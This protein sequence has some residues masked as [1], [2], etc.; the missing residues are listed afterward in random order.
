MRQD[1]NPTGDRDTLR[2]LWRKL[3]ESEERLKFFRKMVGWGLSVRE[4][5][6]LGDDLNSKFRSETMK[7][8]HSEKV[9]VNAIMEMK[10]KDE[11]RFQHEMKGRKEEARRKLEESSKSRNDFKKIIRQINGE[12]KRWRKMEKSKFQS[13][14]EHIKRI[15]E[16][17]EIKSLQEC[18][19]EI[20][21]YAN[22]IIFSKKEFEKLKKER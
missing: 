3:I 4:I 14:I 20:K 6:H 8:G 18:P 5:E 15:R 1:T 12:A 19:P 21:E 13:K 11:R 7:W 9:I 22:I 10:Y 17:E 2:D 16:E